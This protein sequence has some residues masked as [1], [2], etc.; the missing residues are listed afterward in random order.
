M[1]AVHCEIQSF[2]WKYMHLCSM[3]FNASLNLNCVDGKTVINLSTAVHH[4]PEQPIYSKS[5]QSGKVKPSRLRRRKKRQEYRRTLEVDKE[6]HQSFDLP[7]EVTN[8]EFEKPIIRS[9]W[10]RLGKP[11]TGK[12]RSR[13]SK[14]IYILYPVSWRG[15]GS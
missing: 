13:E 12:H 5:S 1:E 4:H 8:Q 11:F 14:P 6:V 7:H 10:T 3:G 9:F 2:V 15:G